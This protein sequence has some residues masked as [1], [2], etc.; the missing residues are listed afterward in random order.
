M[1]VYDIDGDYLD[2]MIND[3]VERHDAGER[4]FPLYVI[5]AKAPIYAIYTSVDDNPEKVVN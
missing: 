3:L 4:I 1:K 2:F 5:Y